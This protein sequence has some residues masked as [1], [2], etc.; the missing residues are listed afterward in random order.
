MIAKESEYHMQIAINLL[1]NTSFL[2]SISIIFNL[3]FQKIQKQKLLYKLLGGIILGLTGIVIMSISLKLPNG[4]IFDTRSILISISGLFYGLVPTSI[5]TLIVVGYRLF[6]GG[7]GAY[8]GIAVSLSSAAL[9]IIWRLIRKNPEKFKRREFYFFGF[10]NHAI[11]LLC[12]LLLPKELIADTLKVISLPVMIIYPFG[13]LALC[14]II[15]YE[16][17][18][19]K[20]ERMLTESESRFR[21]VCEQAPVGI[22]VETSEK[23]IYANSELSKILKMTVSEIMNT[24]WQSYTHPED[25]NKD[26]ADFEQMLSG[27]VDQYDHVKRY[28]RSDG[29]I[30][31]V[32]LYVSILFREEDTSR[33][34]YICIIQDITEEVKREQN[35][36]E[37]ERRQRE[38]AVFLETLLDSIPDHI[39]YKSKQGIYLGCNKAFELASGIP[40]NELVGKDDHEIYDKKTA[41]KFIQADKQVLQDAE[42]I[43]TE[44]T[45]TYPNGDKIITET[46]K[47]RYFDAEGQISG[48]IGISRDITERKKEQERIAYLS[49]HDIMTGLYNRMYY[50]TEL[51]RIDS[52]AL[53]PY[54]II[55]VDIDSLKL[56]NDL[57]GHIAGDQLII[58]TADILKKCFDKGIIA[59]TGGDEFSILMPGMDEGELKELIDDLNFELQKQQSLAKEASALLSASWGYATKN[60]S[61]QTIAEITNAAEEHMYRRKLLKHQSIRSTLFST[62]KELLFSKSIETMEHADRLAGLA[63]KLGIEVG[64]GEADMDALELM[65]TLHDL[66]KIGINS[67]I[68][69]KPG[70]LDDD[71]W[72][73]IRKHPEVGYR[74]ALTI[75]ELQGIAGYILSHHERWD[76]TGYPQGLSKHEI[77]YI[78]RLISV[79]DAF[80]AMTESRPYRNPVSEEEAAREILLHAGTQFDP[81]VAKTF[82][83]HV[84]GFHFQ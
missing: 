52:L 60:R 69:S 81:E 79:V 32:H 7:P 40:R 4:V 16:W 11:M 66:G 24:S 14:M 73:E 1:L 59:R 3:F 13:T 65:A 5:A 76:G 28:F 42:Q 39:F 48:L 84:L 61:E 44:E 21:A 37:S 18:H 15:T 2:V 56:T 70:P 45:V 62:I 58:Q 35:L 31:W 74:I 46:L 51:D 71:E 72:M 20:T 17:K 29:E 30:V 43:R 63:K 34:E 49:V 26:V 75:P 50:D 54:S 41:N 53:F 12:M 9:G 10:V 55:M 64:L 27:A 6:L 82:I 68:L 33:S 23:L 22:A 47:T 80:D 57:F 78:S 8:A 36:V 67:S 77:P 25:L 19:L 83:E 38:A